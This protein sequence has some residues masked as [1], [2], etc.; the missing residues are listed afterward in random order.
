[1]AS[2]LESLGAHAL[3]GDIPQSQREV[4]FSSFSDRFNDLER[5]EQISEW[6]LQMS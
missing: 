4:G 2:S 6:G 3:H 5:K 1:M